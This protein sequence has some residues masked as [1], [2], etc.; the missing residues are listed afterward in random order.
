M[1]PA[2]EIWFYRSRGGLEV[3]LLLSTPE[4]LWGIEVKMSRS[5]SGAQTSA[6]RRLA[7]SLNENWRGGVVVYRG[8]RL[9]RLGD[10]LWAVPLER[11]LS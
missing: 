4:G 8:E 10:N 1:R 2:V 7:N 5:L 11:F 9:E 6:L 3:D